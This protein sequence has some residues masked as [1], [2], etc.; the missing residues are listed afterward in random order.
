MP[1]TSTLPK[2]ATK[3]KRTTVPKNTT[4]STSSKDAK[5]VQSQYPEEA[6]EVRSGIPQ[7]SDEDRETKLKAIR[8]QNNSIKIAQENHKL[9]KEIEVSKGL[10]IETQIQAAKNLITSEQL[11]T[12]AVNL[13][14][15]TTKTN[16]Q[17]EKLN[18]MSVK[19]QIEEVKT[20]ILQTQLE[21]TNIDLNGEK[22]LLP[23]K[24][25]TWNIKLENLQLD[26]KVARQI[27]N[28]KV[29]QMNNRLGGIR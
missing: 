4:K 26:V 1:A 11:N 17:S 21:S 24:Q 13:K 20:S 6:F 15:A 23:L 27:L 2:P 28:D 5:K 14:I 29:A 10:A 19:L 25:E 7:T 8:E 18:G 3:R 16:I 12:E 9:D 22:S